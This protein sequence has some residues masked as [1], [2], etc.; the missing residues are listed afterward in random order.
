MAFIAYLVQI[1][2]KMI[3]VAAVA[4]GGIFLGKGLRERKQKKTEE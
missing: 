4:L 2:V 1:V 3:L